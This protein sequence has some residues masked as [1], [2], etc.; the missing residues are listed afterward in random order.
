MKRMIIALAAFAML[1]LT[2]CAVSRP[3]FVYQD[4][5]AAGPY[6]TFVVHPSASPRHIVNAD[7]VLLPF[8]VQEMQARGYRSAA[9]DADLDITYEVRVYIRREVNQ[10]PVA[11]ADSVKY[12]ASLDETQKGMIALLVT[13]GRTGKPVYGASIKG[14]VKDSITDEQL[15]EVVKGL[16]AHVPA[17]VK[18]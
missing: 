10:T 8:F 6:R 16:M 14:D 3:A 12:R 5:P 2:A 4:F 7:G 17:A 9:Q 15:H 1:Q 11:G 13:D 18:P